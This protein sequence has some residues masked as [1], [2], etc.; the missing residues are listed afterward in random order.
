[1]SPTAGVSGNVGWLGIA[2]QT[3]KGTAAASPTFKNPFSGGSIAPTHA[4]DSLEETDS[5]RDRGVTYVTETG[6]EGDPELYVRKSSIGMYLYSALGAV[7][8]SG[9]TNYTHTITPATALPYMTMWRNIGDLLWER[10]ED[11][12]VSS[13]NITADT[14]GPLTATLGVMGRKSVRLT[15]APAGAAVDSAT[16]FNYNNAAVNFAG[17]ATALVANFDL[18]I[19]NNASLQSTD[20]SVP[21]DVVPGLREVSLGFDMIFEDLTT[22][23]NFHYGGPAGT[24]QTPNMYTT[25]ATFTFTQSANEEIVFD[26]PSLAIEEFPVDPDTGGDPIVVAVRATAQR[27]GSPVVTATVKNQTATY[28]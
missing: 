25:S 7:S 15:S 21:Y 20:D 27:S 11:C 19:D 14:H 9:T 28:V 23:N 18:T 13:I 8:T 6:V 1:V 4:T 12:M 5:S 10:F 2:K 3:A 22:Y 24:A 16:V 17:G 26:L